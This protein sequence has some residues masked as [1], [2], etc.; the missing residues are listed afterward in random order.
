MGRKISQMII[1]TVHGKDQAEHDTNLEL[2]IKRLGERG[3][4]LNAA[5]CKFSMGKLT[6]C[7][8]GSISERNKLCCRQSWGHYQCERTSKCVGDTQFPGARKLL[9]SIHTRPNN[10]IRTPEMSD[11]GRHA[12]L[13]LEKN[14]KKSSWNWRSAYQIQRLWGILTKM[15]SNTSN[16]RREPCWAGSC[17]DPN[18]RGWTK[19]YQF[20]K[21]KSDKYQNKIFT[22][23]R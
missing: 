5:K 6:F 20:C 7:R 15:P 10:Y 8:D 21:P 2:V 3:L 17:F 12:I 9:W 13:Y 11:K 22:N 23:R 18:E 16:C 1:I 4:T 14:R 19:N